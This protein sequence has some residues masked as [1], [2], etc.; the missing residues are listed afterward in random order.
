[1]SL[2]TMELRLATLKQQH[3]RRT[4]RTPT[5]GLRVRVEQRHA[6]RTTRTPTLWRD[7]FVL[8]GSSAAASSQL[9]GSL[10]LDPIRLASAHGQPS[11]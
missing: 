8:D 1:M 3:S 11:G 4:T 6:S 10:E 7:V 9:G 2:A 5:R